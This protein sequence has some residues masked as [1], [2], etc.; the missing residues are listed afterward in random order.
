MS[1]QKNNNPSLHPRNQHKGR[2][3]FKRLVISTPELGPFVKPNAYND[4]SI[5]FAD[6]DA[7]KALN[8]ALLKLQYG[9]AHW[10]IPKGYLCP[11]IPGRADYIHH[12][13]DLL[14]RGN[15]GKAPTG[16]KVV[17]LDI[18]VGAN[19]VY[20]IIGNKEYGWTFIATDIDP[21]AI[22]SASKIAGANA[23]LDSNMELRLQTNANNIFNGM[24]RKEEKI[25]LTIC[26]PPFHSSQAAAQ[27]GSRRKL[28]NLSNKKNAKLTL[29][30]GGQSNELWC[31]GGEKEFIGKMI[32]QSKQF[33]SSC[34]WFSTLVSK[35]AHLD[36]LNRELRKSQAL[37]V[38]TIP[39][40]QGN[41]TSRIVAWTHL[42]KEQQKGWIDARWR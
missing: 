17:C 34:L 16:N 10:D 42:T 30:F 18:G 25:D 24:I 1:A 27:S 40:G 15:K 3:D 35:S 36:D 4:Q 26:N 8:K 9:I 33:A 38:H 23:S 2:Y 7:V 12:I 21:V 39:M 31:A 13:A 22:K 11:P 37:E 14:S 32:R 28:N 19:C 20:P 5:D 6:P 41:K 29:N